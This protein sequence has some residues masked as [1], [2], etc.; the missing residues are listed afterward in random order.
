MVDVAPVF[1]LQGGGYY[2]PNGRGGWLKT[3]PDFHKRWISDANARLGYKL[4]PFAR[5]MKRWNRVHS[6]RLSSF[7]I[8]VMVAN[9]FSAIGSNS[10]TAAAM[11][12]QDGA[13][14]LRSHDPAG[15]SGDLAA[16]LT[17]NQQQAVQQSLDSAKH[18]ADR[19]LAAE[20]AGDHAEAI[21]LW[22]IVFGE[23]FPSY[24]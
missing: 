7:H 15:Y 20:R 2:L 5:L 13:S 4:K 9:T 6:Q 24:G 14:Y 23:E 17:W 3:D 18:R 10:R 12:F 8:E 22:K 11:F 19:A 16:K 21:R 1:A